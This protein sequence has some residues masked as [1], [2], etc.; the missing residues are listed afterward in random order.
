MQA[1]CSA[2]AARAP[3]GHASSSSTARLLAPLARP[4]SSTPAST[5]RTPKGRS[6]GGRSPRAEPAGQI[7][8]PSTP[9]PLVLQAAVGVHASLHNRPRRRARARRASWAGPGAPRWSRSRRTGTSTSQQQALVLVI[10]TAFLRHRYGTQERWPASSRRA[11]AATQRSARRSHAPTSTSRE[12]S[13]FRPA[14]LGGLIQRGRARAGH[15]PSDE[16][17]APQ[18]VELAPLLTAVAFD[19]ARRHAPR[20]AWAALV[21]LTSAAQ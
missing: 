5:I 10:D 1:S 20:L 21:R 13:D 14:E 2:G 3:L 19:P 15:S 17:D 4:G 18:H 12:S 16:A 6:R 9:H 11:A 8:R 7:R